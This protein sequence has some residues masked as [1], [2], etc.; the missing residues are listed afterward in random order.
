MLYLIHG[1]NALEQDEALAKILAKYEEPGMAGLN[2][3]TLEPPLSLSAL[4]H[5]CDTLPFMGENRVVVVRGALGQ[6]N[7]QWQKEVAEYLPH[8]PPTTQLVFLERQTLPKRH[9]VRRLA[10]K[11]GRVIHY[12]VPK[13]RNLPGWIRKRAKERGCT[14]E[15]RA[16]MLLAHN[17]GT[18]LRQLDQEI[19]KLK[20]YR[21]GSGTIT[22]EDVKTMV[23]YVQGADVIFDMVDA[24]GQRKPRVAMQHLHRLLDAGEQH[25]L[26]IFGMIV[27]QYR[28][29][30]QVRWLMEQGLTE[31]QIV[32]RLNLHPYV[33]QK[34]RSQATFFNLE[35]LRRAYDLLFESDLTIKTGRLTP[36]AALDL[37]VAELTR[38]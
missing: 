18:N 15:P 34:M 27:R 12:T 20:I 33:G 9:P 32:A 11:E 21:G 6:K 25:P 28:L 31:N 14:I 29:L 2:V 8:L 36:E 38:L 13:S 1:D 19:Q 4:R 22:L 30:I 17:I 26:Q 10:E 16:T 23:P 37:L 24:L 35:Q 5:A 7:K 3:D